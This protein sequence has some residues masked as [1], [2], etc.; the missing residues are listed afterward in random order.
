MLC[1]LWRSTSLEKEAKYSLTG[2]QGCVARSFGWNLRLV[3]QE[4]FAE[5]SVVAIS[6]NAALQLG[7]S[8]ILG[9]CEQCQ[10]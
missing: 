4:L 3:I 6:S 10:H 2:C 7:H 9:R 1:A 5:S 8:M